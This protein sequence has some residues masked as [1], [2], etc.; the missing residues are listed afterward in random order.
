MTS[1]DKI[2]STVTFHMEVPSRVALQQINSDKCPL[3]CS[4]VDKS[5]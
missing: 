2:P 4:G 1:R 5:K 3:G